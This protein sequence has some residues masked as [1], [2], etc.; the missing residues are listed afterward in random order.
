MIRFLRKKLLN[1]VLFEL[2]V[3][4]EKIK[5]LETKID[6]LGSNTA[7]SFAGQKNEE[8]KILIHNFQEYDEFLHIYIHGD[9]EEKN[10]K[11]FLGKY[12]LDFESFVDAFGTRPPDC[13][14]FSTEYMDW[15]MAFFT[16]LSGRNYSFVSEGITYDEVKN[17]MSL[18]P[19]TNWNIEGN[20]DIAFRTS[21]MRD[22]AEF[23]DI[24][25]PLPNMH[26][27]EMGCGWGYL[28][29]Q[30]GRCGCRITGI[31]ASEG[32][33]AYTKHLL[34]NQNID[35]EIILGSFYDVENID[36]EF[37]LV[38]FDASFHHCGEPLRL[39]KILSNK[40]SKDGRIF[41][42]ND[43]INEFY[44][45]PW[46]IVRYDGASLLQI[47]ARGWLELGHRLDFFKELLTRTGFYLSNTYKMSSGSTLYEARR[48]E[49][50]LQY[51]S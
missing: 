17:H 42:F 9:Y 50:V 7:S 46:G 35:N 21:R 2:S 28:L 38:L 5:E 4:S 33:V 12:A 8:S 44:D 25:C 14:P 32:F 13:D 18:P 29:E 41:F 24:C 30:F 22:L 3:L 15:E 43:V 48:Q 10:D 36:G 26:V 11:E 20:N 40:V 19:T 6:R 16:F 34:S 23:L 47:R 31:D 39:L 45:R 37:D 27:L 49:M 51:E 1:P